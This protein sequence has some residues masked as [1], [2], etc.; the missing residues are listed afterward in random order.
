MLEVARF[1]KRTGVNFL[2]ASGMHR[3]RLRFI[4]LSGDSMVDHLNKNKLW[5]RVVG[6][7][8]DLTFILY[9]AQSVPAPFAAEHHTARIK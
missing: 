2:T 3:N 7:G 1:E 6:L 9:G 4:E 8:L 5:L